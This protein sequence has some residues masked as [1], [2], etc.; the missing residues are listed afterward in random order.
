MP[1]ILVSNISKIYINLGDYD[2][3]CAAVS[4]DGRSYSPELFEQAEKVLCMIHD[5]PERISCLNALGV[6]IKAS[7]LSIAGMENFMQLELSFLR[8]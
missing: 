5:P 4:Q 8:F 7:I 6:K 1:K 2:R 3:F